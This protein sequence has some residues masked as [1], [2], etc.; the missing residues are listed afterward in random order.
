M[1]AQKRIYVVRSHS[2]GERL[3]EA[4]NKAQAISFVA[5]NTITAEVASQSEL[6]RLVQAG[7]TVEG[8]GDPAE[9]D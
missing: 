3:V 8:V 1:A 9:E 5:K 2:G 4:S 7:I 6:V